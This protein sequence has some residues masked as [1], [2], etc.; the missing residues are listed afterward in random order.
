MPM[1]VQLEDG[2]YRLAIGR[3]SDKFFR[4]V[5]PRTR[6]LEQFS[7]DD[8]AASPVACC[9]LITRRWGGTGVDPVAFGFRWFLPSI[10]RYRWPLTHVVI[11]SLI[12]Q[13]FALT[14]PL[15][16]QVII[17]K[18]LVQQ[19]LSTLTVVALG[20][21][22]IALFDALMQF[23]RTYALGHTTSRID[24]ELGSRLFDQ[25]LRLPLAYFNSRST[26][27]TVARVREIETIRSFLTGQALSSL[28]D[29]LFATIFISILFIYSIPLA[30][31]A[32]ISLPVYVLIA[33][34]IGPGLRT[35]INERFNT[36]AAS[37]QFLVETVFGMET[38]K[39]SAVE[40]MLRS[41]WEERLAAYVRSSFQ[42]LVLSSA[43]QSGINF[44]S[45]ITTVAI[46]Y[47]GAKAVMANELSI[48]GLI[49]FNMILSQV[50]AP[51]LR[52]SQLWQDF[53]QVRI[54]VE[55]IGDILNASPEAQRLALTNLP[56]A[57]GHISIE[58]VT[59]RYDH[60]S[61][62]VLKNVSV[63]IAPGQTVGIYGGSGSGKSTLTKLIQGLYKPEHGRIMIDD[64]DIAHVDTT[65]LRRQI[66]VVLQENVLFNKTIHENIALVNPAMHRVLVMAAARLAGADGFIGKLPLGYDTMIEERGLN[67]SG[68]QRQRIALARALIT[69]PRILILDEAT[70]A[71]DLESEQI[72]RRNMRKIS[73]G[74]TVV[75]IAHR[76]ATLR[77]CDKLFGLNDGEL[78]EQGS[79]KDLLDNN[80]SLYARLWRIQTE[81]DD[82]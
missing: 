44:V 45:K 9:L 27:Q 46:L 68:G 8:W 77:G 38:L 22:G 29:L 72:I 71:L 21:A 56:A 62:N 59:F 15:L 17:D 26:G 50:T 82:V 80:E 79:H 2:T 54:S 53:Q 70:S 39:A 5:D 78:V 65:W 66:G 10:W 67:L 75:I 58:E 74:R 64:V 20:L 33:E 37:Q 13:L 35:K 28:L 42:A 3:D 32:I 63:R 41:E 18:V 23:L 31:I 52:L 24:V 34:L 51:I 49:A 7:Q 69:N 25:L 73:E 43:G 16:F 36:G 57:R 19:G 1:L 61:S 12:I 6:S 4:F 48:G 81:A 11:A 30:V 40:P 47:F 76:L 14:T 55:R 60:R